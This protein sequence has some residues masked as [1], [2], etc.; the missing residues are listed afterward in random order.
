MAVLQAYQADLLKDL[1][2]G[3]GLPPE[4]VEE[5]RRTTDL[6]LSATKQT[7]AT[8]GRSMVAMVATERHLWLNLEYFREKEKN[9]L[10]DAS[11]SPSKLFGTSVETVIGKFLEAKARFAAFKTFMPRRSRSKPLAMKGAGS[12]Q[13]EDWRQD[14]KASTAS[15]APPP[16]RGRARRRRE[17][18]GRR[19]DLR[20]V[21]QSNHS[22]RSRIP[23]AN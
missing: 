13:S 14:Q 16:S 21:I 6:D 19:K 2:Q 9:F 5:L 18:R 8:I 23:E 20:E 22:E 7:A 10:L 3:R 11:V 12:S 1:D 17:A 4:A 15:R